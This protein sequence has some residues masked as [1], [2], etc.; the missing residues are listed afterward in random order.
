MMTD[1]I[2]THAALTG[3][4]LPGDLAIWIFILAEMAA[5]AVFFAVYAFARA[6]N[7]ELFDAAQ[8]TLDRRA[9][10][11]NT[12]LLVTGG[13]FAAGA[14]HAARA[15]R[16]A[17]ASRGLWLALAC[18]AGFLLVK[19]FE[20]A[21]KFAAGVSMSTNTFYLFYFSLT[22]FHFLHVVLGMAI[23]GIL[24]GRLRQGAYGRHDVRG[25]ETGTAYWHMVDLLWIVLFPLVY[26]MR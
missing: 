13:W 21:D 20:Y 1:A 9:G 6:R 26:V 10:M 12:L 2:D 19:L 7:V 8:L 18:G 5:F 3:R 17:A 4:R 11:I 16:L 15:D 24:L 23:L 25:L 22:F 14:V